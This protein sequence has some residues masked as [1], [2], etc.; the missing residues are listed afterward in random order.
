[1]NESFQTDSKTQENQGPK[2]NKKETRLDRL[3]R[4]RMRERGDR[5]R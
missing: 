1:M 5:D 2:L 4:E 3:K